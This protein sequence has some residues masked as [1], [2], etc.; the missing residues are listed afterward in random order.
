VLREYDEMVF[1]VL[2]TFDSVSAWSHAGGSDVCALKSVQHVHLDGSEVV[3]TGLFPD[4]RGAFF[5]QLVFLEEP[6]W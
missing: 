1:Y 3:V 4:T 6:H 5:S 2:F